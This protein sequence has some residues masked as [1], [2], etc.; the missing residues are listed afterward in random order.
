MTASVSAVNLSP[1]WPSPAPGR[2]S[3]PPRVARARKPRGRSLAVASLAV[4]VLA[5]AAVAG[6]PGMTLGAAEDV[7]RS[8]DLVTAKTNMSLLRLAGFRAARITRTWAPGALA[9]AAGG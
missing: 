7:V 5:P 2:L 8:P 1:S 3:R 6:G 4:L 9:P